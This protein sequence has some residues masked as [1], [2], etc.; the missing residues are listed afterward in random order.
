MTTRVSIVSCIAA[1]S[2]A[3][4]MFWTQSPALFADGLKCDMTQYKASTGLTAAL[5]QDLLVV[6]WPGQPAV[7]DV[8]R[9]Q[10]DPDGCDRQDR[11]AVRGLQVRR[12]PERLLDRRD[13]AR[14]VARYGRWSAAVPV[15][16]C[17][18]R[19]D[20]AAEGEEPG[21]GRRGQ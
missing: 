18:E 13:A 7:H 17:Q 20:R 16:R 10:L 2:L 19:H 5:D 3:A 6:T 1:S 8:S 15:R 4:A 21:A 12:R 9:H 14:D 11:R